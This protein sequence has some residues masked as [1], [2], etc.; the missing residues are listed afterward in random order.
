ML[1]CAWVTDPCSGLVTLDLLC[2]PCCASSAQ[3]LLAPTVIPAFLLLPHRP[4]SWLGGEGCARSG[5]EERTWPFS[6]R[7]PHCS[8]ALLLSYLNSKWLR[9][10]SVTLDLT[11]W[12]KIS[13]FT[14]IPDCSVKSE[15]GNFATLNAGTID[16][17]HNVV[18]PWHFI[19]IVMVVAL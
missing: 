11:L 16:N 10:T 14:V 1:L 5:A 4:C 2:Q 15:E 17:L 3:L 18:N 19:F 7:N 13:P 9:S 12:I 6:E 8:T